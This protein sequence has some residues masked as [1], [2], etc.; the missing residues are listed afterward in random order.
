MQSILLTTKN[1]SKQKRLKMDKE[2]FDKLTKE[3]QERLRESWKWNAER[4]GKVLIETPMGEIVRV[5]KELVDEYKAIQPFK[6]ERLLDNILNEISKDHLEDDNLKMT[7]FL[8]TIS[9]LLSNSKLRMSMQ[10]TSTT[11]QGK[12]NCIR[13]ILKH[14]PKEAFLFITS[15][16]Q[17]TIEDDVK[18][19]RCLAI[20]EVNLFKEGGAN[21]NLLE[22]I[23]QRTEGGT[24]AIKKDL[25]TKN[26]T[27]RHEEGEQGSV[28]FGTTDVEQDEELGT[29]LMKATIRANPGR[30]KIVN[31]NTLE[32]FSDE[33]KIIAQTNQ[34]DSWIRQ[35]LTYFFAKEEQYGIVIP[36]AK[37]L[38]EKIEGQEI[39]D[40]SDARS[41]RDLKRLLSLTC[42]TTYLFQEQRSKEE[43]HGTHFLVS[44]PEDLINTLKY[45]NEF[46]N[47]TYAGMDLRV[48]EAL[49]FIESK[50][51]DVWV[52]KWDIQEH[53]N[54]K[55]R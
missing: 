14:L 38:K 6:D 24:S 20:S 27:L 10:L 17:A 9:S 48:N 25:R 37:F 53:L 30:I 3:E 39:I 44:T 45:S 21:K 13:A 32:N 43:V 26:K 40:S 34:E 16:T 4:D 52:D 28:I 49:I 36:Y 51:K 8:T 33:E 11:A 31:D 1:Q 23:K 47:Q 2:D 50:G 42:A 7:L 29:R 41:Q 18:Y 54:I 12:D 55:H 35:G 19:K 15:G 5:R 22:I 46:F